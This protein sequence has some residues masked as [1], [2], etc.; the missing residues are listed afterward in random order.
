[1]VPLCSRTQWISG[2]GYNLPIF[3]IFPSRL[4]DQGLYIEV[5]KIIDG[6]PHVCPDGIVVVGRIKFR[7]IYA[8]EDLVNTSMTCGLTLVPTYFLKIISIFG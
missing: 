2:W 7:P 4:A 6:G 8:Y 1:M 3:P 5:M